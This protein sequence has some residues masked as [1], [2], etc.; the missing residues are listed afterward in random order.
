MYP[1]FFPSVF[2]FVL[3]S[4]SC[5]FSLHRSQPPSTNQGQTTASGAPGDGPP[6]NFPSPPGIMSPDMQ[7]AGLNQASC[8]GGPPMM[9]SFAP[10]DGPPH[11]GPSGPQSE[12]NFFNNFFNQQDDMKMDGVVQEGDDECYF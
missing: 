7:N 3:F 6:T 1:I 8:P 10:G 9:G 5:F 11:P 4:T 12:G 2:F